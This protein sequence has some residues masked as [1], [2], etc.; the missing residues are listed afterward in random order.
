MTKRKY[1]V[2]VKG[3]KCGIFNTWSECESQVKGYSGAKYKSFATM[4][5]A[6]KYLKQ[7]GESSNVITTNQSN[8]NNSSANINESE[9]F[10]Q[11]SLKRK[12]DEF[13]QEINSESQTKTSTE[14]QMEP[15][16]KK[17]KLNNPKYKQIYTD[18]CCFGNGLANSVAGVGVW[19]GEDD[20]LN[21]SG[22]LEGTLQ[23][24]Q[25][26]EIKACSIALKRLPQEFQFVELLTDSNYV[27]KA[28]TAWRFVWEKNNWKTKD[29]KDIQ[30]L[31]L[32]L[33]L[34]NE[35]NK[36]T[37]VKFTYVQGHSNVHGNEMA[38]I[39]AKRG[40]TM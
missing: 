24:N 30:N 11:S 2:V 19:F 14:S 36:R 17:V 38:D 39:L 4:E 26:A 18:G 21:Y 37:K 10:D 7:E 1:Y 5:M 23:S 15:E 34:V 35:I 8:P 16:I 20:P 13:N 9:I 32:F 12:K 3:R 40:A 33:E 28:M 22:R 31:D 29:N 27:I 6:E 25:R